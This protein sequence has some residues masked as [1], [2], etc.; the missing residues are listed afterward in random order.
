M[1]KKI[2]LVLGLAGMVVGCHH[3]ESNTGW[4][5]DN[6][7]YSGSTGSQGS[8]GSQYETSTNSGSSYSTNNIYST[9]NPSSGSGN[10]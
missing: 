4:G 3:R 5:S 10:P 9:N 2:A 7:G 6:Q 1:I 8:S